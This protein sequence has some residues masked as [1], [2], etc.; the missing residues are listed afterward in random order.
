MTEQ[1]EFLL[2]LLKWHFEYTSNKQEDF[3]FDTI[4]EPRW[5]IVD[6]RT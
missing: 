5:I 3:P 4:N 6:E 2:E 1:Q